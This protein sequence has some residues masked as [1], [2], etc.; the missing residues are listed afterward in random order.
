MSPSKGIA[1]H[2]PTG[3]DAGL[4]PFEYVVLRVVPRVDRGESIN[5]AVMLY[6]QTKD[7][8][9]VRLRQDL[10]AVAALQAGSESDGCDVADVR[11]LLAGLAAAARGEGVA[12]SM[13]PGGRFRWLAAPRSSTI[14]PGPVHT[15]VTAEPDAELER[16]AARLL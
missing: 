2:L 14:Q 4:L 10:S 1:R 15:G 5:G 8:L 6:C 12:G 3:R 16:L 13:T 11:A 9:G 7:Y